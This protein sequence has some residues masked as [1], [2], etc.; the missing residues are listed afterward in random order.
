M[1]KKV[2]LIDDEK[3]LVET[4]SFRLQAAGYEVITAF[5]GAEGLRLARE[6]KPDIMI[7]DVMMSKMDGYQLCRMLK[8]SAEFRDMPVIMLTARGQEGD[9]RIGMDVGADYYM[10][11]PFDGA[12]LLEK[13]AE[14]LS[15]KK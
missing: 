2:L 10:T 4:L 3:D 12:K 14:L 7:T 8:F 9:K 15:G 11:K 1:P 5:D 6:H 13:M